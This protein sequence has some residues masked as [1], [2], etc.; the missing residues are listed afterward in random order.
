MAHHCNPRRSNVIPASPNGR[1]VPAPAKTTAAKSSNSTIGCVSMIFAAIGI[2]KT[3]IQLKVGRAGAGNTARS[4]V[5]GCDEFTPFL[6]STRIVYWQVIGISLQ[7]VFIARQYQ[8]NSCAAHT[9]IQQALHGGFIEGAY[10]TD[11]YNRRTQG[12][13]ALFGINDTLN[14]GV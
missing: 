3:S 11:H 9:L 5:D 13:H 10:S 8:V 4:V 7:F 1:G 12:K 2:A 6:L 14:R